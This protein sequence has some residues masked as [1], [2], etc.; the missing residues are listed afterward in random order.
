MREILDFFVRNSKWLV[1]VFW[2]TAGCFL[3]FTRNPY[4]QSVYLTSAGQVAG[5]LYDATGQVTSY[6]NLRSANEELNKR[7]AVLQGEVIALREQ[8]QKMQEVSGTY[9]DSGA[10]FPALA[11]FDFITARVVNN[12]VARP[13]N[14]IT[15]NKG[16]RDGVKPEMGVIDQNGV[17]GM[18]NVVSDGHA[19]VL[20]LLNPHFRLSCKIKGNDSFGSLYWDGTSPRTAVLEELPRHTHIN[21]GDTVVTSGHSAVFPEGVPVGIVAGHK[22]DP[23]GN[24]YTLNVTLLGDFARLNNVQVVVNNNADEIRKLEEENARIEGKVSMP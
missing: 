12:S 23:H 13:F 5:T 2:M 11:H 16:T 7:N 17:V 20:S 9:P 8:L 3:L 4:Q 1:F 6:F 21:V 19:R 14:Y 22:N 18:V 15:I 10:V 24:Y